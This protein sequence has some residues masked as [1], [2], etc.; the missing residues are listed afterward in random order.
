MKG[1]LSM[2]L[3]S[4]GEILRIKIFI[5]NMQFAGKVRSAQFPLAYKLPEVQF[6]DK[7]AAFGI[8]GSKHLRERFNKKTLNV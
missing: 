8:E 3:L 6:L 1:L 7:G 2:R 4:G 5:F